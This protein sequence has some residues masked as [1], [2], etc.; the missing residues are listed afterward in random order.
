M[1]KDFNGRIS[2]DIVFA[3][4]IIMFAGLFVLANYFFGFNLYL[5]TIA[6]TIA[7]LLAFLYPR[8][9]LF[10][11]IF[12]TFMFERFF[13]LSPIVLGRVEYKL[14]PIDI[15]M[16]GMIVGL[17]WQIASRKIIP[18]FNKVDLALASFIFLAWI[19]FLASFLIPG[20][21]VP[22]AF[23]AAKNYGFYALLFF[24]SFL[25]IESKKHFIDL[26]KIV[27]AGAFGIIWFIFYGA[28]SGQ[29]L[30][31]EYTP[32]ST[33]G[34]RTLAFTHAFYLCM[35][36]IIS[37][38]CMV[39]NRDGISKY[40]MVFVPL[41]I[42]GIIGS[43]MRHLWISLFAAFV[44]L[45]IIFS[46]KERKALKDYTI[47]YA[48]SVI[49]IGIV[50]FYGAIMFPRSGTYETI[51]KSIGVIQSR[52]V[53]IAD[54]AGDESI[55]WR[56]AVWEQAIKEYKKS[57]ILGIGFGKLIPVE[58]GK[59]HD[60]VEARNV[61]N[62]FLVLLIQTGLLGS[63]IVLYLIL[64]LGLGL[65]RKS[66]KDGVFEDGVFRV[67]AYSAMGVLAL[68]IVA[69]MFQPYLEANMLGI[70]FWINL[71]ILRRLQY[72]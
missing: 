17:L 19:Y 71:G 66:F 41:W 3:I 42:A 55:L 14:Y 26:G 32:L 60:F 30:W 15:I 54:T 43:M 16:G 2:E 50:I 1:N 69:F 44:F 53:S 58:I 70:F 8:S 46:S 48:I 13:T 72:E 59:Y 34:V 11:I 36:V 33:E 63:G 51:G 62:S 52:F 18:K 49:C 67:A 20:N 24:A 22:L 40:L 61:H 64:K 12:L 29:G 10:G 31:S 56:S 5:F 28:M 39:Q 27:L 9:G 57:P 35:A 23:S 68:Q 21:N 7:A 25:L 38:A 37:V 65:I 45:V 4:L 6:I 47:M